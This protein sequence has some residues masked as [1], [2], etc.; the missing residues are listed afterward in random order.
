MEWSVLLYTSVALIVLGIALM[1]I[2]RN[3]FSEIVGLL[4]VENGIAVF[5]L[6]TVGSLPLMIE[7]GI[8]SVTVATAYILALL[9]AQISELH[10]SS[11]TEDL[12]ELIE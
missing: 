11:D 12:R 1:I 7:F 8:F 5:V 3:I 6:A 4:V 2:K 10:G 9:S